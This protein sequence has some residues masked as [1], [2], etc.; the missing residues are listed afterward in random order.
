M[1]FL[2]LA[3]TAAMFL[4]GGGI[5]LH[6]IPFLHHLIDHWAHATAPYAVQPLMMLANGICGICTGVVILTFVN[7]SKALRA[8]L[9]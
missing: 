1:R 6:G 3:G 7:V 2:T 5:V 9:I 4:V 8:R